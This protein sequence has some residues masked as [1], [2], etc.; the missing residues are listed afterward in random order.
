[1][2]DTKHG[3]RLALC[4]IA[5]HVPA[6]HGITHALRIRRMQD[7]MPKLGESPQVFYSLNKLL[8]DA[9]SC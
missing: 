2:P 1:M 4:E 8:R 9:G 7:A 6:K 5:H 3:N